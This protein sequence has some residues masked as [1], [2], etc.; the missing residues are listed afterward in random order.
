MG[1]ENLFSF[2]SLSLFILI[3]IC[4]FLP[5]TS[6][7]CA[8]EK[9]ATLTGTDLAFGTQ[10]KYYDETNF[11]AKKQ[12]N[13]DPE[14][15]ATLSFI[16]ISAGIL[17][18]IFSILS[19]KKSN[20]YITLCILSMLSFAFLLVLKFKLDSDVSNQYE[21]LKLKYEPAYWVSLILS[22]FISIFNFYLFVSKKSE[23]T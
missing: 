21:A 13:I 7:T 8:G 1:K 23:V 9:V 11:S 18:T 14:W 4:F 16:L 5:F 2:V 20:F 17:L 12:R 10:I 3:L 22:V 15:P 19:T 6:I